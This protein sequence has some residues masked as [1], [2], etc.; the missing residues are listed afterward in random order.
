[1]LVKRERCRQPKAGGKKLY[2]MLDEE[3]QQ[4]SINIG[5]DKFMDII[6]RHQM[7]VVR[8]KKFVKTTQSFH[9]FYKY[10]NIIKGVKIIRPEQ[11]WVSDITYVRVGSRWHYLFLITDAYSKKIMGYYL[12]DNMRA[13]NAVVAL[14]MALKNR[15]YPEAKLIHH[16]DRGFQYCCD[17]YTDILKHEEIDIS[18]TAN[19]DPYENAIAERV[20]GILKD[21]F[22]I[23][24]IYLTEEQATKEIEAT[25]AIYN[26][27]RL[28]QSCGF[29]TPEEAHNNGTYILPDWRK[30]RKFEQ[31]Q[32]A[33]GNRLYRSKSQLTVTLSDGS[34][35]T[36][37]ASGE[38]DYPMPQKK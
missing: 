22:D 36:T 8:K 9:R 24:N 4:N 21:E 5:R 3:L 15:K 7:L 17:E 31:P 35:E 11:V 38:P 28:H 20:N 33:E 19:G 6:K 25:I 37:K 27:V 29:I 16:S 10:P 14:Q 18:M 23:E 1:M 12:A 2:L 26:Q 32:M 34:T 13:E 30:K